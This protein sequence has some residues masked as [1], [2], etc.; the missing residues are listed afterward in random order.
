[1]QATIYSVN[2]RNTTKKL[3]RLEKYVTFITYIEKPCFSSFQWFQRWISKSPNILPYIHYLYGS[4]VSNI[5]FIHLSLIS[6]CFILFDSEEVSIDE[7]SMVSQF[8]PIFLD[9]VRNRNFCHILDILGFPWCCL[10][11]LCFINNELELF[12]PSFEESFFNW[13][14]EKHGVCVSSS[15]VWITQ[16]LEQPTLYESKQTSWFEMKIPDELKV[17]LNLLKVH[18]FWKTSF[19]KCSHFHLRA[20]EG[21]L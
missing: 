14:T 12:F 5:N 20:S 6:S 15:R 11:K 17:W 18:Q 3:T 16:D 21:W 4:S 10:S 19:T 2:N 1:M 9:Y 7:F 13:N 8:Q